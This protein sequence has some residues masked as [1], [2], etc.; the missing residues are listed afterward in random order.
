MIDGKDTN[1]NTLSWFFY[2][3]SKKHFVE[4]KIVQE[5]RDVTCSHESEENIDKF[6]AKI[7]YDTLDKMQYLHVALT[8]TLRLYHAVLVVP[9][10]KLS[11][12]DIFFISIYIIYIIVLVSCFISYHSSIYTF[13]GVKVSQPSHTGWLITGWIKK[14]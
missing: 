11:H 3:L 1:A 9:S 5:V 6:V 2:M 12:K 10:T 7:T 4:E 14:E 13:K 8:K